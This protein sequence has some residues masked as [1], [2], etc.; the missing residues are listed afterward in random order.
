MRQTVAQ[1]LG[2]TGM[3]STWMAAASALTRRLLRSEVKMSSHFNDKA[4]YGGI[5]D[6]SMAGTG[7][8]SLARNAVT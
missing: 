7:S 5:D 2:C 8:S 3:G 6:V 1:W 4:H